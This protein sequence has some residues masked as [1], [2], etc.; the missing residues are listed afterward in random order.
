MSEWAVSESVTQSRVC[1]QDIAELEKSIEA[2]EEK[3]S[4]EKKLCLVH[5]QLLVP[6]GRLQGR[7]AF[8]PKESTS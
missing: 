5:L 8:C 4:D 3:I 2:R 6:Q 7:Q 1:A